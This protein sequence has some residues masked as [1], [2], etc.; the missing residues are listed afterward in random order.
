MPSTM[1]WTIS[2]WSTSRQRRTLIR[3][4]FQNKIRPDIYRPNQ[5]QIITHEFCDEE[6]VLRQRIADELR[7]ALK[8]ELLPQKISSTPWRTLS[9][10]L[11]LVAEDVSMPGM[12]AGNVSAGAVDHVPSWKWGNK[13]WRRCTHTHYGDSESDPQGVRLTIW[14]LLSSSA[15][16][17]ALDSSSSGRSSPLSMASPMLFVKPESRF[18]TLCCCG[19]N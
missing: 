11:S 6:K 5:I 8:L 15:D 14:N 17:R 1:P 18:W 19:K 10:C 2:F 3:D 16:R 4:E 12:E 13:R 7:Q 9:E